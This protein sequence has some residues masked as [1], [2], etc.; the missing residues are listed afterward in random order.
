MLNWEWF[1]FVATGISTGSK[2]KSASAGSMLDMLKVA[3]TSSSEVFKK[4]TATFLWNS[5][6]DVV[7]SDFDLKMK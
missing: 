5:V 1:W 2:I 6:N 4:G 7:V 3:S